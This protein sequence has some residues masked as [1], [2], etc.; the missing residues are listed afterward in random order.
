[1]NVRQNKKN[2]GRKSGTK[3]YAITFFAPKIAVS[4]CR[5]NSEGHF[6]FSFVALRITVTTTLRIYGWRRGMGSNTKVPL[7]I[8]LFATHSCNTRTKKIVSIFVVSGFQRSGGREKK[9][10]TNNW[11]RWRLTQPWSTEVR[12]ENWHRILL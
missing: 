3:N 10:N 1:M 5:K 9:Q 4:N 11:G 8:K 2:I 12:I 7:M 6:G